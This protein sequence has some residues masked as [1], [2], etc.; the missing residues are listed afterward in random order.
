MLEYI[1]HINRGVKMKIQESGE[2]YLEAILVLRKETPQVRAIDIANYTGYSKPSVSRALGILKK[3]EYIT[4]SPEGFISFTQKGEEHALR[5]YERH[6]VLTAIFEKIGEKNGVYI[7]LHPH[8]LR[9]TFATHL[10][11]NGADLRLIQELLGHESINT[12]QIYT[13]TTTQ[14]MIKQFESFFPRAKKN[15]DNN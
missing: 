8:T 13:H 1:Q 15:K 14:A 2:M 3:G 5:I 9:H 7:S 6:N 12:T 4:V 11:E 10:L